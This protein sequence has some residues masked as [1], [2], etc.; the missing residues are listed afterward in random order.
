MW[1]RKPEA[2]LEKL[3]IT[4][5]EAKPDHDLLQERFKITAWPTLILIDGAG[6]IISTNQSNN[7]PLSGTDLQRTLEHSP[8][9]YIA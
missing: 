7:L 2:L 4:W 3:Q 1:T 5:P 8:N 6:N 9:R